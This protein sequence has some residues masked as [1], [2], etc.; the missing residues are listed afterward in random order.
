[1]AALEEK[2]MLSQTLDSEMQSLLHADRVSYHGPDT[3]EH[4]KSFSLDAVMTELRAHAPD[5]VELLSQLGH[6]ISH[7]INIHVLCIRF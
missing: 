3:V 2:S 7:K 1:M 4:L 5:V 6:I